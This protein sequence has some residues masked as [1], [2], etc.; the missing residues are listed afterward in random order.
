M[1]TVFAIFLLSLVLVL[2]LIPAGAQEEAAATEAEQPSQTGGSK[3]VSIPQVQGTVTS[4][5]NKVIGYISKIGGLFGQATGFRIGGT[6]VTGI[7]ALVIAKLLE[8][9][10]PSW[11]KYILYA[12]GG[13]M[14]AGSGAN[15]V[16]TVMEN[17]LK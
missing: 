11:V 16:Q 8:D 12:G 7:A 14:F 1:K 3:A 4:L 10:V 6:T 15:I 9:K 13:T 5:L 2:P 17:I